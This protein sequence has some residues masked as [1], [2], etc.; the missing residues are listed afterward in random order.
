VKEG[1][2][3]KIERGDD[4]GKIRGGRREYDKGE[5]RGRKRNRD[6]EK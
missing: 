1:R 6:R 4:R 2:K 3:N 5:I